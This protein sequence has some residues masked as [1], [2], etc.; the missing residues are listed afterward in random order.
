M[1]HRQH[2]GR[3]ETLKEC[4]DRLKQCQD[5]ADKVCNDTFPPALSDAGLGPYDA[6]YARRSTCIDRMLKCC[7]L[8]SIEGGANVLLPGNPIGVRECA[9]DG[10][11]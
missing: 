8:Q 10:P 11:R 1:A 2:G 6:N 9:V 5:G 3:G 4:N 7:V